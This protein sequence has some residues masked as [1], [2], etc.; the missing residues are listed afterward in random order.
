MSHTELAEI[1][2]QVETLTQVG[3]VRP[4][5]SQWA[6]PVLIVS[7]KDRSLRCSVDYWALK[8]ELS[9]TTN[10]HP[11]GSNCLGTPFF[12]NWSTKLILSNEN[13]WER[14]TQD[15]IQHKIQPLRI[16]SRSIRIEQCTRSIQERPEWFIQRLHRFLFYGLPWWHNRIQQILVRTR[17]S[18]ETRPKATTKA[19]AVCEIIK[20]HVWSLR[21][22]LS[23]I[24]NTCSKIGNES[25]QNQC[26]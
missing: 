18:C 21:S 22:R 25:R 12:Y 16:H 5:K 15:C 11:D 7:K 6:S 23:W 26:N 19:K 20:M 14:H 3:F 4:S 13:F 8:E 10:R 17:K 9:S 24:R 2:K 1:K